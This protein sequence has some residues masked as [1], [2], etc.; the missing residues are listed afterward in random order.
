MIDETKGGRGVVPNPINVRRHVISRQIISAQ[1]H[2]S[3][4]PSTH[5]EI[6][7]IDRIRIDFVRDLLRWTQFCGC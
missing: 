7:S 4:E 5:L 3:S 6:G 1:G 2:A